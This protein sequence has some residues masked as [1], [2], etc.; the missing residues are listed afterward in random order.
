M[1]LLRHILHSFTALFCLA[2]SDVNSIYVPMGLNQSTIFYGGGILDDR[3]VYIPVITDPHASTVWTIGSR[4]EVTWDVSSIPSGLTDFTGKIVLG[5]LDK[6]TDEH[7]D[8]D[9]PLAEGFNITEGHVEVEV[10]NV[11]PSNEYIVV[12]FGD[13]GNRSPTFTIV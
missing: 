5:Y 4:A 9:N 10:P 8:L 3:E 11:S 12:L 13:S 6:G 2:V 1:L 7:L